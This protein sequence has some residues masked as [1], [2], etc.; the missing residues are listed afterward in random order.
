VRNGSVISIATSDQPPVLVWTPAPAL[1][2]AAWNVPLLAL[3]YAIL[4]G[5][6]VAA[7]AAPLLRRIYGS[8]PAFERPRTWVYRLSRLA[9]FA[10]LAFLSGWLAIIVAASTAPSTLSTPLDPWLRLLQLVGLAAIALS[11]FVFWHIVGLWKERPAPWWRL[12]GNALLAIACLAVLWFTVAFHLITA[13][14]GY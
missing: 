14:L 1:R 4:L 3:T 2:S 9:A 8:R 12:I 11:A 10:N 7:V 5:A 6:A 13:S